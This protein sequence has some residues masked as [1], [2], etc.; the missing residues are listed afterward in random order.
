[1]IVRSSFT[2]RTTSL[3]AAAYSLTPRMYRT[4]GGPL[5]VEKAAKLAR[6]ANVPSEVPGHK[7]NGD[8]VGGIGQKHSVLIDECLEKQLRRNY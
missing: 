7:F 2:R 8:F 6:W 3:L 4:R 5:V 1:V